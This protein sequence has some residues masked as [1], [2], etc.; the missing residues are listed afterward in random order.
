[1]A[2]ECRAVPEG[3]WRCFHCD[4]VFLTVE[5]ARD[6]FGADST[7]EPGCVLKLD[8]GEKKVIHALREAW[9]Q[10]ARYWQEDSDMEREMRAM[11][12][13]HEAALRREEEFDRKMN[14]AA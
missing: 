9:E 10:L 6:H 3:G 1:M 7:A 5:A 13:E 8:A 14:G 2:T 12:I 11:R 4:E